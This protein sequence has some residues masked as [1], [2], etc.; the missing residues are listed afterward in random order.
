MDT[1]VGAAAPHGFARPSE[2][3]SRLYAN[4]IGPLGVAEKRTGGA[5]GR[6]YSTCSWPRMDRL[7]HQL[8]RADQRMLAYQ[9]LL[10]TPFGIT[11][12]RYTMLYVVLRNGMELGAK[13]R[14]MNQSKL[15]RSL[16]VTAPTVSVT[17]TIKGGAMLGNM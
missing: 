14:T 6:W 12:A 16:G 13:R 15:R 9:R 4:E 11:P 8:K 3:R 1:P 2:G 17:W 7:S 10:L 5:R